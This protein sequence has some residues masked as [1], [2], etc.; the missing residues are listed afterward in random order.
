MNLMLVITFASLIDRVYV[1]RVLMGLY[2]YCDIPTISKD[3]QS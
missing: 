3:D 2:P 1:E